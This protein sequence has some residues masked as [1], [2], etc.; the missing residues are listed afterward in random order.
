MKK[1][2]SLTIV[3]SM[4][5]MI[6]SPL[7]SFAETY[8]QSYNLEQKDITWRITNYSGTELTEPI[9]VGY[10]NDAGNL[11][12]TSKGVDGV[13]SGQSH[14]AEIYPAD[15]TATAFADTLTSDNFD[16]EMKMKY[17][18][19]IVILLYTGSYRFYLTLESDSKLIYD[20]GTNK[21]NVVEIDMPFNQWHNWT[22]S[23]RNK[24]LGIVSIDGREV[25][26]Y[27]LQPSTQEARAGV[28]YK[29]RADADHYA[30][31]E[32]VSISPVTAV[33][34]GGNSSSSS[35][36]VINSLNDGQI[37]K[38]GTS[39]NL[40]TNKS[41]NGSFLS[42]AVTATYYCDG[43]SIGSDLVKSSLFSKTNNGL[44]Y[45]FSTAGVYKIYATCSGLTSDELTIRVQDYVP[46]ITVPETAKYGETVTVT[47]NENGIADRA[48]MKYYVN[49]F[50]KL[51][52][53]A[54][55]VNFTDLNVGL[56]EIYAVVVT[57]DN[58]E[59]FTEPQTVTITDVDKTV[60]ITVPETATYGEDVSVRVN[61]GEI[62]NRA[63]IKYY[64]NG[65]YVSKKDSVNVSLSGLSIGTSQI[66]ATVVCS[67]GS[68][69]TSKPAYVNVVSDGSTGAVDIRRE[70]M[71]DYEYGGTAV[72]SLSIVDGYFTLDFSHNGKIVSYK[73]IDGNKTYTIMGD[74]DGSGKFRVVVTA[75]SAEV[76]YNGQFA[77]SCLLPYEPADKSFNYSGITNVV[78]QGSGVKAE[79]YLRQSGAAVDEYDL[80]FDKFYSLEF[81]KLNTSAET[82]V[83]YDG[84]YQAKL[85]FDSRG[86]TAMDQPEDYKETYETCISETIP[87]GYYRLTV[88]RGL[89]QLFVNNKYINSFKC[90]ALSHEKALLRQVTRTADSTFVSIKNTDD[91]YYHNEDFE[92]NTELAAT[93]YWYTEFGAVEKD[94]TIDSTDAANPVITTVEAD[95]STF[96]YGVETADDNTYLKL[97]GEGDYSLNSSADNPI[98]NFKAKWDG[99][100]EFSVLGR[101][102]IK[103]HYI[104]VGYGADGWFI[105]KSMYDTSAKATGVTTLSTSTSDAPGTGWNNYKLVFNG[106]TVTLYCNDAVVITYT[107][108]EVELAHGKLGFNVSGNATLMVDDVEYTGDGKA[109]A[110]FS[111]FHGTKVD[112][113][114]NTRDFYLSNDNETIWMAGA[115]Y[116][117]FRTKDGLKWERVT[118][119]NDVG[120]NAR[121][122]LSAN[123]LR[124]LSGKFLRVGAAG[125][126]WV[127]DM[128]GVRTYAALYEP[129][130]NW[131]DKRNYRYAPNSVLM[132]DSDF[133]PNGDYGSA[134]LSGRLIQDIDGNNNRVFYVKDIGG[135]R[136]GGSALFYSDDEGKSWTLAKKFINKF[137]GIF[138]G[139]EDNPV[140]HSGVYS[141]E[142]M[143]VDM[144]GDLL[145]YYTRTDKGFL[146][147]SESYDGGIT[148][149]EFKPSEFIAPR[150]SY[151]IV[152]DPDIENNPY[153]YY[154]FWE[155]DTNTA[156][157]NE[158]GG[159]PRNR[160]AL[161]V[162]RDGMETWEYIM[163][164]EELT[165]DWRSISTDG[166]PEL[167]PDNHSI[168]IINGAVYMTTGKANEYAPMY[169][170]DLS[171]IK[172]LKR[173]TSAH[174]RLAE[175]IT[176]SDISDRF[177]ILPTVTGYGS[178]YGTQTSITVTDGNYPTDVIA[179]VMKAVAGEGG[180]FGVGSKI[181][182]IE[183]DAN[184][185]YDIKDCASAFGMYVTETQNA[186][187]I[188]DSP[189]S[190]LNLYQLS[191]IGVRKTLQQDVVDEFL[192]EI[193]VASEYGY[194]YRIDELIQTYSDAVTLEIDLSGI[195]DTEAVFDRMTGKMYYT[196]SDVQNAFIMACQAQ[197][198]AES[199][200]TGLMLSSASGGFDVWSTSSSL[201]ADDA[202]VT[203]GAVKFT[204]NGLFGSGNSYGTS[205]FTVPNGESYS[206][207]FELK[208]ERGTDATVIWGNGKYKIPL[209]FNKVND[210]PDDNVI[211]LAE[212]VWN[213]IY[214]AVSNTEAG[215]SVSVN[216]APLTEDGAEGERTAYTAY[217]YETVGGEGFN[218]ELEDG[219]LGTVELRK[220]RVYEGKV[221]DVVSYTA[222]NG[223]AKATV[224]L[225]N[226]GQV[227]NTSQLVMN[228]F[229]GSILS[230]TAAG[231]SENEE[232]AV[233]EYGIK[234]FDIPEFE[235]TAVQG[236]KPSL[237]FYL[238]KDT[239]NLQPVIEPLIISQ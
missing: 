197:K 74:G 214:A 144:P 79:R 69:Y 22:L 166:Y 102:Y 59:Y 42:S 114:I 7:T 130:E 223:K 190:R 67:D 195:T 121:M 171:K 151:G 12:L 174:D 80:D 204:A 28:F 58:T 191:N 234:Q 183:P 84:E 201:N 16:F 11:V 26:R 128:P 150:C 165:N 119:V 238:W 9:N 236:V 55:T 152:R 182:T 113:N 61:T 73:S 203:D 202:V 86:I 15:N 222:A 237:H 98:F 23:V 20:Y 164:I 76:Y 200:E 209:S 239:L 154:A 57:T 181:V 196:V 145:R 44:D 213:R 157:K 141:A 208:L 167:T 21:R 220:V 173:F 56:A 179:K 116:A 49:G 19:Q 129:D 206:V 41:S 211:N 95:T 216:V 68:E 210:K 125:S 215:I 229:S 149:G 142:A 50:Y 193:N 71:V 148:W 47:V 101:Y 146:Y 51:K 90:P 187:V 231:N 194:G 186:Y 89:A 83:V 40:K 127:K 221:L 94:T 93:D 131:E 3:L 230:G 172:T 161:A 160:A 53:D 92:G 124:L 25:L 87:T 176:V 117:H 46:T 72:G 97:W 212:D 140:F 14:L 233:L 33:S 24:S 38:T 18:D 107:G 65:V 115:G 224:E 168:R 136:Y 133:N 134:A 147:Y 123:N 163:D 110:G 156:N 70:Y 184:G 122:Y 6:A 159:R 85:I 60:S 189:I 31:I 100:G 225:L 48:Y 75:G 218:V 36:L 10:I 29:K 207:V 192:N 2:I 227:L 185:N 32:Y 105:R 4:L 108:T 5:C 13:V 232:A 39:V 198:M 143:I 17:E 66:H 96:S 99:N 178:I 1:L 153:T 155:Y 81:D 82:L 226:D 103:N 169:R 64:I 120:A 139:E 180:T 91:I 77:F 8:T 43:D 109:N 62:A 52:K 45:T 137:T 205:A 106:T 37:I 54:K 199:G 111:Y 162:S 177:S 217:A 228:V 27:D 34:G 235:Y 219:K 104:S 78:L 63:Y 158:N 112:N 126:S 132:E 118:E 135:E 138:A 175:Y 170:V 88:A 30:E 35:S 188:S